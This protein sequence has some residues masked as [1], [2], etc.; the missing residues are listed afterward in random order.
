MKKLMII[1][2]GMILC[3][4]C[5]NDDFLYQGEEGGVS[6]IYFLKATS[7]SMDGTPLGYTDSVSYSFQNDNLS[8]TTKKITIPVKLLGMLSDEDRSFKVKVIGGN[9]VE[10]EDFVALP[11]E[12]IFPAKSAEAEAYVEIIRTPKL[13]TESRY[14][15][16]ELVGN[17]F[18]KL[19]L[20]QLKNISSSDTLKTNIFK[21]SFTEKLTEMDYYSI[22]GRGHFGK[23]SV[24]KFHKINEIAGWTLQDWLSWD[25]NYGKF[26]YVATVLRRELQALADAGKPFM[27]EENGEYMQLGDSYKVD[28]SKYESD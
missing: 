17:D 18:F 5:E 4:G 8:V 12:F 16:V 27:D 13:V 21:I 28:Y 11:E 2:F 9:A 6:G 23:W 10:G 1:F 3:W 25:V 7:T 20:P 15:V 22:M 14:V 24:K 19:L 26:A